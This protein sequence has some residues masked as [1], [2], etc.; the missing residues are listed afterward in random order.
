MRV[1]CGTDIIEIERI[2]KSIDGHDGKFVNMIFTDNE[3]RY[4]ESHGGMK[5]QHYA[6]RFAA[7]EAIYK[8]FSGVAELT[9]LD[10]EVIDDEK[11]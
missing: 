3:K 4:C 10:V 5:Y 11:R 1:S 6:V 2:R 8:A 7:K 9:W